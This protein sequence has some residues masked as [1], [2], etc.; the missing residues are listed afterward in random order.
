M[1]TLGRSGLERWLM[2]VG[3]GTHVALEATVVSP[4]LIGMATLAGRVAAADA[5]ASADAA[6]Y[7]EMAEVT[8]AAAGSILYTTGM[9]GVETASA[10]AAIAAIS[11]LCALAKRKPAHAEDTRLDRMVSQR[12]GRGDAENVATKAWT[13]EWIGRLVLRYRCEETTT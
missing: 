3:C 11:K 9:V 12:K 10:M 2:P 4:R 13:N 5:M 7:V 6:S 8:A 1:K